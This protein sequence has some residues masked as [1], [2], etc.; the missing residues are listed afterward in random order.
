MQPMGELLRPEQVGYGPRGGAEAAVHS[1]RL[2]VTQNEKDCQVLLKLDFKNAFNKAS[3][4]A[5]PSDH[6]FLPSDTRTL[7]VPP[8]A[9][10]LDDATV[11]GD[12]DIVLEDLQTV[13]A[14]VP[15]S[16]WS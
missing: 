9:L 8:V 13:F 11:G 14:S 16:A 6:S 5:I 7:Q 10:H 1:A 15:P 12:S 4:K 3:N 2:F